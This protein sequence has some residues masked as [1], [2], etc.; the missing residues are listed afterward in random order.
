MVFDKVRDALGLSNSELQTLRSH[1]HDDLFVRYG[2]EF[3]GSGQD[4]GRLI[5]GVDEHRY[6]GPSWRVVWTG[7]Q[8]IL[9][10]GGVRRF[11]EDDLQG[12]AQ[13][14]NELYDVSDFDAST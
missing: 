12:I 14:I 13:T 7:N 2:S 3:D 5:F 11:E 9:R 10:A 1:L 6:R 8:W 4:A